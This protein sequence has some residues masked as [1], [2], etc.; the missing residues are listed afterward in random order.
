MCP[1]AGMGPSLPSCCTGQALRPGCRGT[2]RCPGEPAMC[3]GATG[4][5]RL[6]GQ[7]LDMGTVPPPAPCLRH[8][9]GFGGRPRLQHAAPQTPSGLLQLN[10]SSCSPAPCQGLSPWPTDDVGKDSPGNGFALCREDVY[11]QRAPLGTR[12]SPLPFPKRNRRGR[13][14]QPPTSPRRCAPSLPRHQPLQNVAAEAESHKIKY[15]RRVCGANKS[16]GG[17]GVR[18]PTPPARG[19]GSPQGQQSLPKRSF[20]ASCAAVALPYQ[21]GRPQYTHRSGNFISYTGMEWFWGWP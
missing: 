5:R 10:P 7:E 20:G 6:T 1:H 12:A 15:G 11:T 18:V 17:L 14:E 4:R 21:H 3:R 13:S 8:Q 19:C 16:W 9:L 2:L